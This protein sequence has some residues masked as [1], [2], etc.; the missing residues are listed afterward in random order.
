MKIRIILIIY[1]NRFLINPKSLHS[2][3]AIIIIQAY[4]SH[5]TLPKGSH[6]CARD[7]TGP[8]LT[9]QLS[10]H[11]ELECYKSRAEFSGCPQF[12]Q[13]SLPCLYLSLLTSLSLSEKTSGST[14]RLQASTNLD[15]NIVI[16]QHL[17]T[18]VCVQFHIKRCY[19]R[20]HEYGHSYLI[21]GT[22]SEVFVHIIF[23]HL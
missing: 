21:Q 6:S 7:S 22:F 18:T 8:L 14:N 20:Q 1:T 19:S 2:E 5:S 23:V 10:D 4:Q 13:P 16:R 17:K 9:S 12:Y 15:A 11:R 3:I